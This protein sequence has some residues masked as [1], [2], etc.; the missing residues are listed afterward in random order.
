MALAL[1]VIKNRPPGSN[2]REHAE[3]LSRRLKARDGSWRQVARGLQQ[4][5]LRLQQELLLS[6]VTSR[7]QSGAR[8]AGT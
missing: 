6:R 5:V 7:L 8:A 3:D 4:E 2:G 1:V